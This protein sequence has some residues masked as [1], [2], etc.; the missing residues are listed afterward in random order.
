MRTRATLCRTTIH[1]CDYASGMYTQDEVP[2]DTARGGLRLYASP[3]SP[4]G[5]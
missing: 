1:S 5:W 4:P 2:G 3:W